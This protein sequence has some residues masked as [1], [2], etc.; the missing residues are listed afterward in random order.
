MASTRYRAWRFFH[1]D[2]DAPEEFAGLGTTPTGRIAMVEERDSIRQSILLLLSTRPGERVMRP[3]YGCNIHQLVFWPND[4]TTAGLAL[5]YVQKAV[6][7]WEPRVKIVKLDA[8]RDDAVPGRLD[9]VLTY[10]LR[11][12]RQVDSMMF[13]MNVFGEGV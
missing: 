6:N 7:R 11:A 2:I 5:H 8:E 9:I 1:P 12:S 4:D 13:S 3:D 10:R